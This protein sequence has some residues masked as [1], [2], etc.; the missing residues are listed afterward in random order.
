MSYRDEGKE[1]IF[2]VHVTHH[3]DAD[4]EHAL[5]RVG[6]RYLHADGRTEYRLIDMSNPVALE[7]EDESSLR[8]EVWLESGYDS[9]V[10]DPTKV[11]ALAPEPALTSE[12]S[13]EDL[14]LLALVT[15]K[16]ERESVLGD[17]CERFASDVERF[18]FA[19][20]RFIFWW[21]TVGSTLHFIMRPLFVIFRALR[22]MK[23]TS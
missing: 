22:L 18:G 10:I 9:V 11:A 1:E 5:A 20:A 6:V 4:H 2:S 21:D 13:T 17:A 15:S 12:L 3:S 8:R 19:R 14:F 7:D 16:A 23:A